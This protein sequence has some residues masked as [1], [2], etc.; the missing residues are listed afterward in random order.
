[1]STQ[2]Q[3]LQ[4]CFGGKLADTVIDGNTG[5]GRFIGIIRYV[6]GPGKPDLSMVV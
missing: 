3:W 1:M 6:P 4:K 2:S 5:Y